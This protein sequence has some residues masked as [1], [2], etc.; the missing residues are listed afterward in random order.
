MSSVLLYN[1]VNNSKG[2]WVPESYSSYSNLVVVPFEYFTNNPEVTGFS[3]AFTDK[4]SSVALEL[5]LLSCL[6]CERLIEL[7]GI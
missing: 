1:F 7:I 3:H 2:N 6:V 5:G 4:K